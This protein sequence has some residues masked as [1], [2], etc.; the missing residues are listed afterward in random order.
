[1]GQELRLF[2][3]LVSHSPVICS[4]PQ[5]F[6]FPFVSRSIARKVRIIMV[7]AAIWHRKPLSRKEFVHQK[8]Q[9]ANLLKFRGLGM[10]QVRA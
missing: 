2:A 8:R 6:F 10:M 3:W 7:W 9:S 4:L 5:A 1:M